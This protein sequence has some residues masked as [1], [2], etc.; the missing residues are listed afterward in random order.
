MQ[1]D[2]V[3]VRSLQERETANFYRQRTENENRVSKIAE[4]ISRYPD[5][6]ERLG[7]ASG[8]EF[9]YKA[10]VPEAYKSV[11]DID[12]PTLRIQTEN[13]QKIVNAYNEIVLEEYE[14][15]VELQKQADEIVGVGG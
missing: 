9:S 11:A 5:I 15:A 14:R 7:L 4:A 3:R 8:M 10:L 13:I 6:G 2:L 1:V 12:K